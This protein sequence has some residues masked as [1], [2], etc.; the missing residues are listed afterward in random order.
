MKNI[1]KH[2]TN[3]LGLIVGGPNW[4]VSICREIDPLSFQGSG[5]QVAAWPEV[6]EP[7]ASKPQT[8]PSVYSTRC[9]ITTMSKL[10]GS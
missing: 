5:V 8:T 10:H 4:Y 2:L 7:V 9:T 6:S 3:P 1:L